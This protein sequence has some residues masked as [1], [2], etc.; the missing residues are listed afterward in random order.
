MTTQ[1]SVELCDGRHRTSTSGGLLRA[2]VVRGPADRCRIGLLATTALLLGGDEVELSVE[3]GP[4]AMLEL[5]DVA[6]T[7]AYHGRGRPSGWRVRA[8][9]H[10]GARLRWSG[11]P[12]VVSHGADVLRR[13]ELDLGEDARAV[14]RETVVLGRAG[15]PGGRLRNQTV[16]RRAGREVLVE[17]Q[18]LDPGARQLPGL[19]GA[20][21]VIDSVLA[22]G[23]PTPEQGPGVSRFQ[24]VETGS[25]LLRHLGVEL[26]PS[27]L[28]SAW[29]NLQLGGTACPSASRSGLAPRT[30]SVRSRSEDR[31]PS[32]VLRRT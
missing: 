19:L 18:R 14:L 26:A 1:I 20:N 22:F 3:V 4:G 30:A 27:P 25:T 5:F 32:P 12:L 24:L 10:E 9:V 21:R 7:V 6:G 23:V 17:D 2:Q 29:A 11:E 31:A 16:V 8:V 28:H 13:L 15:E